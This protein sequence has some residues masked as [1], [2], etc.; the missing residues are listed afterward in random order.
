MLEHPGLL[1]DQL[2]PQGACWLV[3]RGQI[4]HWGIGRKE[5]SRETHVSGDRSPEAEAPSFSSSR[6]IGDRDDLTGLGD[7]CERWQEDGLR[8]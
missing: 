5:P 2:V 3:A 7:P 6:L 8:Q 4:P 1:G